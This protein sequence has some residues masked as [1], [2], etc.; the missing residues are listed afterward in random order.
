M[1]QLVIGYENPIF[2]G[3]MLEEHIIWSIVWKRVHN[4]NNVP[5]S[6]G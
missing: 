6:A 2:L 4:P 3:G 5:S 1:N